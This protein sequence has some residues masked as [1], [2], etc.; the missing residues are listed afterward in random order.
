MHSFLPGDLVT[1]ENTKDK[2]TY[3]IVIESRKQFG[4]I[5]MRLLYRDKVMSLI[6]DGKKE[7][8]KLVQSLHQ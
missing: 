5:E 8:I 3:C 1:I 7:T 4:Y 2:Y 6:Y